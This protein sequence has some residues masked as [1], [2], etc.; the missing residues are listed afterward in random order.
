MKKICVNDL[1]SGDLLTKDVISNEGVLLIKAGT[2]LT[3]WQIKCL[4]RNVQTV[5]IDESGG[6][7]NLTA[8]DLKERLDAC[9]KEDPINSYRIRELILKEIAGDR[10]NLEKLAAL[11]KFSQETYVHSINICVRVTK[12]VCDWYNKDLVPE[13]IVASI[14]HDIGKIK[15]PIEILEK[16]DKLSSK[17]RKIINEHSLLGAEILSGYNKKIVKAVLHHHE[18][19]NGKGYPSK[20][21][22]KDIPEFAMVIKIF[23][24]FTA[25]IEDRPYRGKYSKQQA[26]EILLKG[27]GKE[28]D[29]QILDDILSKIEPYS[30]G[31]R[32]ILEDTDEEAIVIG[33]SKVKPYF[34]IVR[35][36]SNRKFT[37]VDLGTSKETIKKDL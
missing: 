6:S 27:S 22:G 2:E 21:K 26:I 12:Y 13:V 25:L 9:L 3:D 5:E 19:Y 31:D 20:L 35:I 16:T 1:K 15:I 29:P 7:W 34:P 24:S 11:K 37:T 36:T 28:Y 10:K 18:E 8:L 14:F 33:K 17:E 23:D 32:V 30:L 4:K